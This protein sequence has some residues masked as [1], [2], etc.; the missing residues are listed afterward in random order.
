MRFSSKTI[1]II[2]KPPTLESRGFLNTTHLVEVDEAG[3]KDL[4]EVDEA[5]GKGVV[6]LVAAVDGVVE[7]VVVVLEENKIL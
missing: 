2:L 1:K 5:G 4:V 3:G 7:D 6:V